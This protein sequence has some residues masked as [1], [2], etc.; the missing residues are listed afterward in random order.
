MKTVFAITCVILLITLDSFSQSGLSTKSKKAAELYRQADNYR[1]RGQYIPAID[2]LNQAIKKDKNFFEAYFRLGVIHKAKGDLEQAEGLLSKVLE[3]NDKNAG[4]YFELSE[5]Y[6]K[7]SAYQKSLEYINK[8]LALNPRNRARVNEAKSIK[9][10]ADFGLKNADVISE[11]KPR[12]L[13]DTVN[14]FPMQY[15]PIVTVDQEAIIFTRRLGRTVHDDEDIVISY[16]N[17]KGRWGAPTSISENINTGFNEGTCTISADGRTLIMTSCVGRKGY[18]SCDLFV[19]YKFG[20][21]WTTPKNLGANVNSSS[22]DSQPSLSA[23]GRTLYFVS[24]RGGGVGRRDIWVSYKDDQDKWSKAKNL[25]RKVNSVND[26]ISPFIHPNNKTL[27]FASNGWVGFGGLDIFSSEYDSS[28]WTKPENLGVPINTGEDQVALF[29]TSDGERGYYSNENNSLPDK[30]NF[31]YE[32]NVPKNAKVKYR[33]SYVKGV[34]RD[35]DTKK[36]L[37]ARV[38]LYDLKKDQRV[39]FV[40]S[41][42]LSGDYLMVLTEGSEYALYINKKKYLFKSLSFG[43]DLNENLEPIE[44]DIWLEPIKEGATTE[45]RNIF[46]EVNKFDLKDKSKTELKRVA[47]FLINNPQI[48]VEIAGHTDSSGAASFNVQLSTNRAKT[49]YQFLLNQGVSKNLLTYKGYGASQPAHPND[50]E[51]NK[52]KNRRIEFIIR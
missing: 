6:L 23:D 19:A 40:K 9:Q 35:L 16:K 44:I 28:G 32:F 29:I 27:Y 20:N 7:Q 50:S 10:N 2:L 47:T 36:P 31:I 5:L 21:E 11:F 30:K 43:Y 42:S 15:F 52:Q 1:V 17:D 26:D 12:A 22:W 48:N 38:E 14:R 13:S 37:S 39:A 25:G 33:T 18:G 51:A 41:D 8:Y 4:A 24:N 34:I 46:F 45:L 3:L 49:V